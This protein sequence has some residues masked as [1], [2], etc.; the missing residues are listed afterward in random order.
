M[1]Q[2]LATGDQTNERLMDTALGAASKRVV[3]KAPCLADRSPSHSL[4]GKTIRFD[5]Y[6]VHFH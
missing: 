6:I 3:V 4:I 1:L 5:V 2:M